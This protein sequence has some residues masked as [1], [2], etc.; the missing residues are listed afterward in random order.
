MLSCYFEDG[1]KAEPSLRHLAADGLVVRGNDILL[2]RRAVHLLEG[3]KFAIPGGYMNRDETT[4]EAALREVVEETGWKCEVSEFFGIADSPNRGD[5]RQNISIFFI[6]KPLEETE[7]PDS[8]VSEVTWFSL[9][10]LPKPEEVA[11]DHYKVILAYKEYK[12]S[13]R[14]LP[15]F[16]D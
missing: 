3:G 11:F 13:K 9:D 6:M 14:K 12:E 10:K 15:V 2:V 8:E 1:D 4:K 7:K 5:D 16:I